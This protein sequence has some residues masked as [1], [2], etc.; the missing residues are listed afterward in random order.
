MNQSSLWLPQVT[1]TDFRG[2]CRVPRSTRARESD[3]L[4]ARW[5][6]ASLVGGRP[7]TS[8]PIQLLVEVAP[9]IVVPVS[10]DEENPSA[11]DALDGNDDPVCP[12]QVLDAQSLQWDRP[13]HAIAQR[14]TAALAEVVE[15]RL[16][17]AS[18]PL[19]AS[20]PLGRWRGAFRKPRRTSMGVVMTWTALVV[21]RDPRPAASAPGSR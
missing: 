4:R 20:E 3:L 19:L 1:C 2:A 16:I 17:S 12:P 15:E 21:P 14:R 13:G 5:F 18:P 9:R 11:L 8:Q 6:T 10:T 7:G